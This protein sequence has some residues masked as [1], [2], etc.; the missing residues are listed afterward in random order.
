MR[1][2]SVL[3]IFYWVIKYK[4]ICLYFFILNCYFGQEC[5]VVIPWTVLPRCINCTQVKFKYENN[6]KK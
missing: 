3:F 4:E 2:V 6:I 5:I 1:Q